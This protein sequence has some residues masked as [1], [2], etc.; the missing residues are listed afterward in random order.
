MSAILLPVPD[1][2][3]VAR[4]PA[5]VAELQKLLGADR[6]VGDEDGRRAYETDALTAYRRMP[7]A[8]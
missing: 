2:A 1:A 4:R 8:D 5:I 3:I 7:L 6:V